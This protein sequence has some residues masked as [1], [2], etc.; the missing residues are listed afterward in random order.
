MPSPHDTNER[1]QAIWPWLLMPLLVLLVAYTLHNFQRTAKSGA[2]T[3]GAQA[4]ET[5]GP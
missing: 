4:E 5:T 2:S 3:R 1:R